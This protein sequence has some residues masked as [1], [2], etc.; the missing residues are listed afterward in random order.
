MNLNR[1]R[2]LAIAAP[3]LGVLLGA[4]MLVPLIDRDLSPVT[5]GMMIGVAGMICL[6]GVALGIISV[7]RSEARRKAKEQIW[8]KH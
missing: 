3:L 4:L 7:R 5:S 1:K 6:L 8:L 2:L